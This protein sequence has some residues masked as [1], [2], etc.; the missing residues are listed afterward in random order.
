MLEIS[1]VRI[2]QSVGEIDSIVS[3]IAYRLD[4]LNNSFANP[5]DTDDELNRCARP[6]ALTSCPFLIDYGIDAAAPRIHHDDRTC[7]KAECRNGGLA[8]FKILAFG[9]V[10]RYVGLDFV[11]HRIID[12]SLAGNR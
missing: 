2:R 8:H 7:V 1:V 12:C 9:A 5:G 3:A 10:L 11:P 6:E 4:R